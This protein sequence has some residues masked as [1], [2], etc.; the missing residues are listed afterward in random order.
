MLPFLN[1]VKGFRL[2]LPNMLVHFVSLLLE[3]NK[4]FYSLSFHSKYSLSVQNPW[5]TGIK[6]VRI[7]WVYGSLGSFGVLSAA[8]PHIL[9][10]SIMFDVPLFMY[11]KTVKGKTRT[12]KLPH[13][14]KTAIW[15][16][17]YKFYQYKIT[18]N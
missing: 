4:W 11:L 10:S 18:A 2:P 12:K 17:P 15:H 13:Q 5:R 7:T 1:S 9:T 3:V 16:M 8:W 6:V 14:E